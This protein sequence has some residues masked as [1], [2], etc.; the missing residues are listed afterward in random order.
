M[1]N[2]FRTRTFTRWMQKAGLTDEALRQAVAEMALGLI[3]ADL[4][5][6]VVK[7]RVALPGGGKQGGARTIV[8]TRFAGSWFFLYGFGKAEQTNISRKELKILQ[9]VAKTFLAF[10]SEQ[11]RLA[12]EAGEIVKVRESHDEP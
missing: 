5:A 4:G 9:E 12:L 3:D 6:H 2:V 8:A 1:E 11:L 10:N 7:K